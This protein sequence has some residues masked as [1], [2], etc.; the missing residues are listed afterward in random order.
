MSTSSQAKSGR[1]GKTLSQAIVDKKG[2]TKVRP[3][4]VD[5]KTVQSTV[6]M[7]YSLGRVLELRQWTLSADLVQTPIEQPRR[8]LFLG[9][10]KVPLKKVYPVEAHKNLIPLRFLEVH[11]NRVLVKKDLQ[12]HEQAHLIFL[13]SFDR[14]DTN[15]VVEGDELIVT[16]QGGPNDDQILWV[17]DDIGD[18]EPMIKNYWKRLC[19]DFS[20]DHYIREVD[21]ICDCWDDYLEEREE[22][23]MPWT[24][25]LHEKCQEIQGT[26]Y[27]EDVPCWLLAAEISKELYIMT[28]ELRRMCDERLAFFRNFYHDE[29]GTSWGAPLLVF[30]GDPEL[31]ESFGNSVDA[32]A[33]EGLWVTTFSETTYRLDGTVERRG[34]DDQWIQNFHNKIKEIRDWLDRLSSP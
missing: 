3:F 24:V 7:H 22:E 23:E 29:Y 12:Y 26:F 4:F 6:N 14:G 1:R 10:P 13:Q 27:G 28:M 25:K 8:T 17:D 5:Q 15:W 30:S 31:D 20:G 32:Y 19:F 33:M 11:G 34:C 18:P 2:C 16:T 21:L 9:S